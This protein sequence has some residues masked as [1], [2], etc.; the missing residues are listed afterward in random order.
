MKINSYWEKELKPEM[1]SSIP[2]MIYQ[3]NCVMDVSMNNVKKEWRKQ[4]D[5]MWRKEQGTETIQSGDK[6][7]TVNDKPSPNHFYLIYVCLLRSDVSSGSKYYL[8][9]SWASLG[10]SS[11]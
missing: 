5:T 10:L 1:P 6:D 11:H 7:R 3:F 8:E 4:Y 9:F 2:S